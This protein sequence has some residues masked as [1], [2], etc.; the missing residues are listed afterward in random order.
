MTKTIIIIITILFIVIFP[1]IFHWFFNKKTLEKSRDKFIMS[2][3]FQAQTTLYHF[4]EKYPNLSFL[5]ERKVIDALKFFF[6]TINYTESQISIPSKIVDDLW[7]CFLKDHQ[8]Y[9]RF[10]EQAFG[11]LIIHYPSHR[12]TLREDVKD[13]N[14]ISNSILNTYFIYQ[15]IQ[16]TNY[17]KEH[18]PFIFILDKTF[19]VENGFYYEDHIISSIEEKIKEHKS[20]FKSNLDFNDSSDGGDGGD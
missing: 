8:E 16:I 5:E 9:V 17:P 20:L 12:E 19:G 3:R 18:I 6:I 10:C 7:I 15:K 11:K 14:N 2:Y 1:F 13:I 4:R